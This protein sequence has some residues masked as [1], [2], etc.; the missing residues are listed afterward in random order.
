MQYNI[1]V[2][3]QRIYRVGGV[4][5]NDD[6]LLKARANGKT[7]TN[8]EITR[9]SILEIIKNKYKLEDIDIEIFLDKLSEGTLEVILKDLS[10]NQISKRRYN[11]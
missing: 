2:I 7:L 11:D 3:L 5:M 1:G 4:K 6:K 9:D 10:K 8:F